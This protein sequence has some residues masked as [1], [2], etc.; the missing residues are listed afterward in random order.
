MTVIRPVL[1]TTVWSWWREIIRTAAG[2]RTHCWSGEVLAVVLA[3][4][5]VRVGKRA[6]RVVTVV[7][8]W[9]SILGLLHLHA[10]VRIRFTIQA[11]CS[12]SAVVLFVGFPVDH[13]IG[14]VWVGI[15]RRI[16][17]LWRLGPR[18]R[19]IGRKVDCLRMML[20]S[21][22]W[23]K[24]WGMVVMVLHMVWCLL[25][26]MHVQVLTWDSACGTMSHRSSGLSG[27]RVIGF[28]IRVLSIGRPWSS[29]M[30]A[31]EVFRQRSLP[32]ESTK[33]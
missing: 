8:L 32:T 33:R 13:R 29:T 23:G 6:S 1:L 16:I 15:W 21:D 27:R 22:L 24:M 7:V 3:G 26:V 25:A 5:G 10:V 18:V 28:F 9:R 11:L 17:D 14:G 30:L 4:I 31:T 2:C 20:G 12:G 19:G